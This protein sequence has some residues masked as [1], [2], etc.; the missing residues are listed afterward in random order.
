MRTR[1]DF[2]MERMAVDLLCNECGHLF[3][4]SQEM[5][6]EN[7]LASG[8]ALRLIEN[9]KKIKQ[10]IHLMNEDFRVEVEEVLSSFQG[11]R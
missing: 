9:M 6:E 7:F 11:R 8:F 3:R 2:T 5:G 1:K 10:L 4:L